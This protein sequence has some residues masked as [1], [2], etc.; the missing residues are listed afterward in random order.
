A[1]VSSFGISG[2]NAHVILAEAPADVSVEDTT[3]DEDVRLDGTGLPWLVSARSSEALAEAAERL[4]AYVRERPELGPADVALSLA[5]GRSA[6][7]ARAAL[8]GRDGRDGLLAGLDALASGELAAVTA[9]VS[10]AKP[11]RTSG[12]P[13]VFVFPG[14]GSQWVGMATALLD[15][16]PEFARVITECETALTP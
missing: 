4:A 10:G 2:T 11:G 7:E 3:P 13:V 14:Q 9:A 5:T 6:F 8:P 12:A 15:S 16:S 1:G